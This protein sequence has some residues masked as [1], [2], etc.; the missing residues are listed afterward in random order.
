MFPKSGLVRYLPRSLLRITAK[1]KSINIE[2]IQNFWRL[3]IDEARQQPIKSQKR[4]SSQAA[5]PPSPVDLS[6]DSNPSKRAKLER[7][8][9]AVLNKKTISKPL[10]I[11]PIESLKESVIRLMRNP[12][13]SDPAKISLRFWELMQEAGTDPE[14]RLA[15]IKTATKEGSPEVWRTYVYLPRFLF[16]YLANIYTIGLQG[17][18]LC[19]DDYSSG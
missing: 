8:G 1:L 12:D 7:N 10:P 5:L 15:L 19:R 17:I 16:H 3:K 18:L 11:D 9:K 14:K 13:L 4:T 2:S 6:G